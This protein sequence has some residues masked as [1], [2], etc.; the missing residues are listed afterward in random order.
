[1]LTEDNDAK[2]ILFTLIFIIFLT[3]RSANALSSPK[4]D[5]WIVRIQLSDSTVLNSENLDWFRIEEILVFY[6]NV[7]G[8][9][10]LAFNKWDKDGIGRDGNITVYVSGDVGKVDLGA[11]YPGTEYNVSVWIKT[12]YV[13]YYFLVNWTLNSSIDGSLSWSELKGASIGSNL[14][15]GW[16]PSSADGVAYIIAGHLWSIKWSAFTDPGGNNGFREWNYALYAV[17]PETGLE[18]YIPIFEVYWNNSELLLWRD[19]GGDWNGSYST[20]LFNISD[21]WARLCGGIYGNTACWYVEDFG[22]VSLWAKVFWRLGVDSNTNNP[23]DVWVGNASIK[24]HVPFTNGFHYANRTAINITDSVSG[25]RFNQLIADDSDHHLARDD[26]DSNGGPTCSPYEYPNLFIPCWTFFTVI[27]PVDFYQLLASTYPFGK[28]WMTCFEAAIGLGNS[29]WILSLGKNSPQMHGYAPIEGLSY[30]SGC[31]KSEISRLSGDFAWG[32]VR[33][34]WLPNITPF[35]GVNLT[36]KVYYLGMIVHESNFSTIT[37]PATGLLQPSYL[38]IEDSSGVVHIF[39]PWWDIKRYYTSNYTLYVIYPFVSVVYTRITIKDGSP[40]PEPLDNAFVYLSSFKYDRINTATDSNGDVYLPPWNTI[41]SGTTTNGSAIEV[42]YSIMHPYGLLPVPWTNIITRANYTYFLDI[43]WSPYFSDEKPIPVTNENYSR[44]ELNISKPLEWWLGIGTPSSLQPQVFA[45]YTDVYVV[46]LVVYDL[47]YRPLSGVAEGKSALLFYYEYNESGLNISH[48]FVYDLGTERGE[49]IL[50]RFPKGRVKLR[51]Y[52]KGVLLSPVVIDDYNLEYGKEIW[53]NITG[54]YLIGRQKVIFPVG[55]LNITVTQ[56]DVNEPI[57]NLSVTL[58]YLKDNATVYC[59]PEQLTS[60][61]GI[62][63]YEYVPIQPLPA[64]LSGHNYTIR[65]VIRTSKWTP[66]IRHP[67]D[68]NILVGEYTLPLNFSLSCTTFIT[69]PTWIYSPFIRITDYSGNTLGYFYN[70]FGF[71]E[72]VFILNDTLWNWTTSTCSE[73][74][75][76]CT[77][78]IQ[79]D[80]RIINLTGYV[81]DEWMDKGIR[82]GLSQAVFRLYSR[83]FDPSQPHLFI[84]GARYH[85]MVFYGGVLVYNYSIILPRPI[86]PSNHSM[87]NMLVVFYNESSHK[88]WNVTLWDRFNY[89][90]TEDWIAHPIMYFVG[91]YNHTK[92][93]ERFG[94]TLVLITWVN[95]LK[96]YPLSNAGRYIVPYLNITL[97]RNDV[98]NMTAYINMS[99]KTRE[100]LFYN[101]SRRSIFSGN[102]SIY[103]W[104]GCSDASG[105]AWIQVPVWVPSRDNKPWITCGCRYSCGGNWSNIIFGASIYSVYLLAGS[106]WDTPN[107]Y[108]TPLNDY[109]LYHYISSNKKRGLIKYEIY[110]YLVNY[111]HTSMRKVVLVNDAYCNRTFYPWWYKQ[112]N[113]SL[114]I[115]KGIREPLDGYIFLEGKRSRKMGCMLC[116]CGPDTIPFVGDYWNFTFW[117]E[118]SKIVHTT[119]A[120]GFCIRIKALDKCLREIGFPGQPVHVGHDDI[121]LSSVKYTDENGIVIYYPN[122]TGHVRLP[123]GEE[124]QIPADFYFFKEPEFD[125]YL[126]SPGDYAVA[127]DEDNNHFQYW[128]ET[129]IDYDYILNPYGLTSSDLLCDQRMFHV[130]FNLTEGN[131]IPDAKHGAYLE[132]P[133][134]ACLSHGGWDA[135]IFKVLDWSGKPLKDALVVVY[136]YNETNIP[137]AFNF[138]SEDGTAVIYVPPIMESDP[139]AIFSVNIY[140]RDTLFL[141][142]T[143]VIPKSIIIY[144]S[145]GDEEIPRYF[146]SGVVPPATLP[147]IPGITLTRRGATI[148][149]YVY[150]GLVRLENED[151]SNVDPEVLEKIRVKIVWPDKVITLHKPES[152]G[153]V[154]IILNK[155]TAFSFPT[156]PSSKRNPDSPHPQSPLGDYKIIVE[157]E[158][159]GPIVEKT[160]RITKGKEEKA[161]FTWN[162]KLPIRDI[163]LSILTPFETPLDNSLIEVDSVNKGKMVISSDENGRIKLERVLYSEKYPLKIKVLKWRGMN[164]D[165]VANV[166]PTDYSITCR[167]I[168]KLIVFVK[169]ERNQPLPYTPIYIEGIG[170]HAHTDETGIYEIELPEGVYNLTIVRGDQKQS[171]LVVIEG[172][173]ITKTTIQFNVFVTLGSIDLTLS[174]LTGISLLLI[175]LTLVSILVFKEYSIWRQ[176]R[177]IVPSWGK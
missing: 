82:N 135:L 65:V 107:V 136:K 8:N 174:E 26:M 81:Q 79:V 114:G 98:L 96:I 15:L 38:H 46:Q 169:G 160:F 118:A 2:L 97:F 31:T 70:N 173:K 3:L 57:M 130:S 80:Y 16:I 9:E 74:P 63:S 152:D 124:V 11:L 43:L 53:I 92:G 127:I 19:L 41:S 20:G 102:L 150:N 143:G 168:G 122:E 55:D 123:S 159:I 61:N 167:N 44:I 177:K 99:T 100:Y 48:V 59:E 104:Y 120:D 94:Q 153:T 66:Y 24:F 158:N 162:V 165:Y 125:D 147:N 71:Y 116:S 156:P 42:R 72:T 121:V 88:M 131:N 56:W 172:S 34:F 112:A 28:G 163:E 62:V 54:N 39:D 40:N 149:T 7:T 137:Y 35:Y 47:C 23:I 4:V 49:I 18:E 142:K 51:L 128:F 45:I 144:S 140:W 164:I 78:D 166:T 1:M 12:E 132:E 139:N 175:V 27:S 170:V 145:I 119:L 32:S 58:E 68:D 176:R 17:E 75:C 129:W 5:H 87:P 10:V 171:L 36:L 83:Q 73:P 84:A 30:C 25:L 133:Y 69:L 6:Y 67:I 33:F 101:L 22:N 86:L 90:W 14:Y 91:D 76:N 95:Y 108:D 50:L 115:Y 109:F 89:S 110:G 106:L 52:W 93:G 103:A 134:D 161:E 37:N 113:D 64:N 13:D 29:T 21:T 77:L 111:N 138:T 154:L 117:G 85:F 151:E 126:I 155:D 60:C 141:E 157:L 146:Y 148:Y 105:I